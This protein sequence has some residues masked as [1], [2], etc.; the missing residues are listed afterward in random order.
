MWSRLQYKLSQL[1]LVSGHDT[2]ELTDLWQRGLKLFADMVNATASRSTQREFARLALFD[3]SLRPGSICLCED[4]HGACAAGVGSWF[5]RGVAQGDL[6]LLMQAADSG[7]QQLIEALDQYDGFF[8]FIVAAQDRLHVIT[9]PLGRLHIY[10]CR[11]GVTLAVSTSALVLAA[12]AGASWNPLA[13]REFLALGYV[14]GEHSL[15]QGVR[16][17]APATVNTQGL[18]VWRAPQRRVY[19]RVSD[20]VYEGAEGTG[21]IRPLADALC[22]SVRNIF[23]AYPRA[24]MD[25]TGGF[26][27]RAL[28]GA[29][30]YD[31]PPGRFETVVSGTPTSGD[32]I[33]ARGIAGQFGLTHRELVPQPRD[34]GQWWALA[35]Q[36][37]PLVD[38]EYNVLEYACILSIH[39]E[40]AAEFDA[41]ING[42]G[43]EVCR[44]YW[45]ELLLP[46]LGRRGHFDPL[47][48]AAARFA[49]DNWAEALL[50]E[51]FRV[52]L[53]RHIAELIREADTG[54]GECLNT[55]RMDNIY[56]TVRMQRWQGR[57]AS[58]TSRLWPCFSPFLMKGPLQVALGA[59]V[60]ERLADR[61]PRR[62]IYYFDPQL[63][64]LPMAS[65]VPASPITLANV[66]RFHRLLGLWGGRA[67]RK[68]YRVLGGRPK[69]S[70]H[71]GSGPL[72]LFWDH[73]P[74]RD[75]WSCP[76]T[77]D[78]YRDRALQRFM[79]QSREPGFADA[80]H[81]GRV[82][83]LELVA[84]ALQTAGQTWL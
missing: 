40:L 25:L 68:A 1:F 42:S 28:L 11:I 47:H 56:L 36:A 4:D 21:G 46:F 52:P 61:M 20:W 73:A 23:E 60:R 33:A 59:T 80:A 22:A 83:T 66:H 29:A 6:G 82:V 5:S 9:D 43:G 2:E 57:I 24:A 7:E 76:L 14:L 16:K 78:L 3:A 15:F 67:G 64:A 55:A 74:F 81:F 27:S 58:A 19:W 12:L 65:G 13:V 38:G 69:A 50:A 48:V 79:Q 17:L 51:E 26:D 8:A 54:L 35:R 63:A 10:E 37:V 45:W 71:S 31:Y 72:G 49:T 32:V 77:K 53:D 39:S 84:R 70:P 30:L 41:S 18:R 62:L 34:I 44:G 75:W